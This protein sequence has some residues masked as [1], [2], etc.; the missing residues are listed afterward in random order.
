[1][2]IDEYLFQSDKVRARHAEVHDQFDMT[3]VVYFPVF[4]D[5]KGVF[6][7]YDHT[8]R[9]KLK[10][11]HHASEGQFSDRVSAPLTSFRENVVANQVPNPLEENIQVNSRSPGLNVNPHKKDSRQNAL[12]DEFKFFDEEET[13]GKLP[14]MVCNGG[15]THRDKVL[16]YFHANAEDI[17]VT[18][19]TAEFMASFLEV[20]FILGLDDSDL[21]GVPQ[22]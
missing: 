10:D 18:E 12:E 16:L 5:S 8:K 17:F 2:D 13:I 11:D 6:E 15:I 9:L 22:L 21:D 20:L 14:C 7:K 19:Q 4:K 1:M 3:R